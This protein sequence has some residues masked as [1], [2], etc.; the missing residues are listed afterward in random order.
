MQVG[1]HRTSPALRRCTPSDGLYLKQ[2]T[3]LGTICLL[4]TEDWLGCQRAH[5]PRWLNAPSE[6]LSRL[7]VW[8]RVLVL[9]SELLLLRPLLIFAPTVSCR[10]PLV[11]TLPTLLLPWS[12]F[13]TSPFCHFQVVVCLH[14]QGLQL[15]H[16]NETSS[17]SAG[18]LTSDRPKSLTICKKTSDPCVC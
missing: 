10:G 17:S 5:R 6:L 2:P 11:C 14:R 16:C 1:A 3:Y 13:V 15:P 12:L 7:L 8:Q 18:L 9:N 4:A